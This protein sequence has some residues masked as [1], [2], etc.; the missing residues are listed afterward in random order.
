MKRL[1]GATGWWKWDLFERHTCSLIYLFSLNLTW[2]TLWDCSGVKPCVFLVSKTCRAVRVIH[3]T[4]DKIKSK[5]QFS[6][7][8]RSRWWYPE[9]NTFPPTTPMI[10]SQQLSAST[11]SCLSSSL[12]LCLSLSQ[13][14]HTHSF[15]CPFVL[16]P[17]NSLE[18]VFAMCVLLCV[19]Q[20]DRCWD[21]KQRRLLILLSNNVKKVWLTASQSSS[22]FSWKNDFLQISWWVYWRAAGGSWSVE[23]TQKHLVCA[24]VCFA[25][26]H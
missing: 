24:C 14:D 13:V 25:P 12:C 22:C 26:W 10:H 11:H 2:V 9:E 17:A 1:D 15:V 18:S 5:S 16:S 20:W 4:R 7:A 8:A 21:T 19:C 3:K 23:L 6:W